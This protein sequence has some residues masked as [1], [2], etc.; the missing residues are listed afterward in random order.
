MR[1]VCYSEEHMTSL[2]YH[3]LISPYATCHKT[4]NHVV[5]QCFSES[6]LYTAIG[7]VSS[8]SINSEENTISEI[9][10]FIKDEYFVKLIMH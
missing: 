5:F 1:V 3:N 4:E 7:D 2:K 6:Y 9:N 8:I 10:Y